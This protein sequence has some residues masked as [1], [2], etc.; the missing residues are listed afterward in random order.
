MLKYWPAVQEAINS[1]LKCLELQPGSRSASQNRLLA[2]NY[3]LEGDAEEL[4]DAHWQWGI[5]FE[6]VVSRLPEV[7]PPPAALRSASRPLVV[8]YVSPD[9]ITHSVSYFA[10]APLAL[11]NPSRS[12]LLAP[13]P[14]RFPLA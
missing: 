10:E 11:H 12:G 5:A 3:V 1:Y 6:S 14:S 8:G 9:F 4:Y 7:V 2:L 13:L